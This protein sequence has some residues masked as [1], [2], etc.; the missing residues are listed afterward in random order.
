MTVIS[1]FNKDIKIHLFLYC[2]FIQAVLDCDCD[3]DEN[4]TTF[5][6]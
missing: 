4:E 3:L 6:E 5:Y 2:K 1:V